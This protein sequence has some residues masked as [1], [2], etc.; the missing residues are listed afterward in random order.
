MPLLP[1]LD[2]FFRDRLGPGDR[3]LIAFSGGPDSTALLHALHRLA[4]ALSA[5]L[6]AAHLDHRLDL[7]SGRRARAAGELAAAVGVPLVSGRLETGGR[8]PGESAEAYARRRRYA[9]LE[10]T[11]EDLGAR[12]VVTAHHAD[13]QAET[14]LLR[15]LFGSGLGGLAAIRPVR[16]RFV[17][18]LLGVRRD[19]LRRSLEGSGLEPVADPTN[20]DLRVP[21]NLVR[22]RLLPSLAHADPRIVERLGT[23]ASSAAAARRRTDDVLARHLRLRVRPDGAEL[24]RRAFERLPEPLPDAALSLLDRRAG[25]P[26]PAGAPARSELRRQLAGGGRA[27]CD[28]GDGGR[29]EGDCRTLRRLW[30]K[31]RLEPGTRKFAYTLEVPGEVEIP[32][33]SLRFRLERGE[34]APWMFR[35][36]S[37]RAGLAVSLEAGSRVVIRNRRPGDRI[38]PLGSEER[39]R[40][41]DLLISRRIPKS[42]RDRLPLLVIDDALAWVPGVTIDERFRL[43][44]EPSTADPPAGSTSI[45][46]ARIE[47]STRVKP[48][49]PGGPRRDRKVAQP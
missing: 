27:G 8:P 1:T 9:F 12:C 42:R 3:L 7:D 16:G 47:D 15:L 32:E 38:Q 5:D 37:D 43:D 6:V 40:L 45:W 20:A 49:P 14:V 26:Y 11:A 2:T 13:D 24:D 21:R 30:G 46:I 44:V 33:L 48:A 22:H 19:E 35:G 28:C 18:P 34:A 10:R 25:V 17:R 31:P 36:R 41:K 39:Q 23:L 29:W 4:P